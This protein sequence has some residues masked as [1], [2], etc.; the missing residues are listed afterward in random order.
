MNSTSRAQPT[1][2]FRSGDDNR[3]TSSVNRGWAEK[4]KITST[5]KLKILPVFILS[6]FFVAMLRSHTE[7]LPCTSSF[8]SS[9]YLVDP[10]PFIK[11]ELILVSV[12]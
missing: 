9:L 12:A 7:R 11:A 6:S 2:K 3:L 8:P 5:K 1:P 4:Q 10:I